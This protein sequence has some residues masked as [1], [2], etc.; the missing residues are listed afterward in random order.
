MLWRKTMGHK[1]FAAITIIFL[2]LA[3]HSWN[4]DIQ[5]NKIELILAAAAPTIIP[6]E[7]FRTTSSTTNSNNSQHAN[8]E[9]TLRIVAQRWKSTDVNRDGV[10][11]CID[12]AVLFYHYYPAK[13]RVAIII[14]VNPR[15]GMNHLFNAV[16]INGV[17]R[18]IEPQA[19]TCPNWERLQ[20]YFMRDIWGNQYN[21]A[22]NKNETEKWR[23]Y[24]R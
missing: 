17:W 12:A 6:V 1:G 10:Y 22:F 16:L 20:T 18:A 2:I 7:V 5:N 4:K 21:N 19:Y 13:D 24:A 14:N 8:I 9:Q 11:N 3:W 23:V 15:T